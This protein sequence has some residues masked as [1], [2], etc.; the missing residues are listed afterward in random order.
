MCVIG[1]WLPFWGRIRCASKRVEGNKKWWTSGKIAKL[2]TVSADI[3]A[4]THAKCMFNSTD[5][6]ALG[7]CSSKH[8]WCQVLMHTGCHCSS[9]SDAKIVEK[10][11]LL[12]SAA[13]KLQTVKQSDEM[14][15]QQHLLLEKSF[16]SANQAL[17]LHT[18][19]KKVKRVAFWRLEHSN[20]NLKFWW[21]PFCTPSQPRLLTCKVRQGAPAH[22][23]M[24]FKRFSSFKCF[25][26]QQHISRMFQETA[27]V[28]KS[29][30]SFKSMFQEQNST[31]ART[32]APN[33]KIEF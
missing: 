4:P 22:H 18:M 11:G 32:C 1:N 26:R 24:S 3:L 25:K 12:P 20:N 9:I 5:L 6:L 19:S 13:S 28:V 15:V 30:K 29:F 23:F 2:P 27:R 7:R 21:A 17:M 14:S 10:N 16:H 33:F 31:C 8:V